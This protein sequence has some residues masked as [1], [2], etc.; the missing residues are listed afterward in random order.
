MSHSHSCQSSE[1]TYPEKEAIEPIEEHAK[2][3]VSSDS[4]YELD[5]NESGQGMDVVKTQEY[6]FHCK[7]S[8]PKDI[9]V[10]FPSDHLEALY[11]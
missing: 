5:S 4:S 3:L 8:I 9:E 7:Y 10:C 1:L 11:S 6:R 2:S